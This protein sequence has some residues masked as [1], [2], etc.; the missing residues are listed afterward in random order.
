MRSVNSQLLRAGRGFL[1]AVA[2]L[3]Q[4]EELL[5]GDPGVRGPAQGEDLP[6]QDSEGPPA[7]ARRKL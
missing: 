5:H 2:L 4:L 1:H 3:Q 6:Q 7:A